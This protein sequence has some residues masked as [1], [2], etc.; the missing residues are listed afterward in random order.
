MLVRVGGG[1]ESFL[2]VGQRK[3]EA[4]ATEEAKA[5]AHAGIQEGDEAAAD[6]PAAAAQGAEAKESESLDEY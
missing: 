4:Q 5:K 2:E 3:F 1:W 6:T